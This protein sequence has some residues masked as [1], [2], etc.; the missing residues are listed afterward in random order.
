MMMQVGYAYAMAGKKAE[1]EK[2]LAALAKVARNRYVPSF[3]S[4]AI[5][6]GMRDK[7]RALEWLRKANGERCDYLIYLPKEPAADP[8]REAPEF[9][10]LVPRPSP[11]TP[12]GP[13]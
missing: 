13:S 8:I 5:H 11:A 10:E 2:M 12:V 3:Y 4:A 9:A 1:A 6:A 7:K